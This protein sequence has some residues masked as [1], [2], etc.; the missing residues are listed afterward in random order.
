[1]AEVK[2]IFLYNGNNETIKCKK[3]E[4]MLDIYKRYAMKIQ[5]DLEKL[6]FLC[7][8]SM[9]NPEMKLNNIIKKDEKIINMIV[10]E[11]INDEDN[12]I[13]LKKSKDIICPI[14]NEICLINLNDYRITFSNCRNGHKFNQIMFEEYYDFQ[15]IDESKIICDKC[16]GKD[17][18][19]KSEVNN[20]IFYKCFT[21]NINICP[22][23]KVKHDKKHL[24]FNY[25]NKNYLCNKHGERYISLCKECKKALCD[26]CRYDDKH[27]SS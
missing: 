15:K 22:L 12:E 24:I 3:G 7:N 1:M 11:L 20:N 16:V 4:Y 18:N 14:C 19:K 5:V 10:N 2:I 17:K 25:D 27:Y 8:G 9:I 26:N 21:C 6:Y 13:N 23:C